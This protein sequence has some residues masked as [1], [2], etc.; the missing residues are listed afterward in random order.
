[1]SE[2]ATVL[3]FFEH[4]SGKTLPRTASGEIDMDR[5][6]RDNDRR[7]E[8]SR[9]FGR[10]ELESQYGLAVSDTVDP[11]QALAY[12]RAAGGLI[13][14]TVLIDTEGEFSDRGTPP[15]GYAFAIVDPEGKAVAAAYWE[16]VDALTALPRTAPG[17]QDV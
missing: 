15:E 17:E 4:I 12:R 2:Q 6:R 9:Q 8:Q 11:Q 5:I 1:M 7:D 13:G 3:S 14:I 10:V 16:A